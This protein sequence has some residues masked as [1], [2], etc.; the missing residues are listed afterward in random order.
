MKGE[1]STKMATIITNRATVNYNNGS[2]T[3]TVVSNTVSTQLNNGLEINKTA[4]TETYRPDRDITYVITVTNNGS[5]ATERLTVTDD[6]GAYLSGGNRIVPLT[7]IGPSQLFI[8]GISIGEITPITVTDGILFVI[9]NIPANSNAQIIYVARANEFAGGNVDSCIINTVTADNDC[10]CPCDEPVSDSYSVCVDV[11]ADLRVVKC[12]CPDPVVCGERLNYVIELYNYGNIPATDVV[13]TD[14]F[15][16]P[17]T[18]IA[19]SVNG[20]VIPEGDYSYVNG[21]LILPASD[22]EFEITVPA[23]SFIRD[24][25]TGEV[26]VT[27]GNVTVNISGIVS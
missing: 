18:D 8:N 23:A 25:Q 26:S 16:P 17:L 19:V 5:T 13:I 15:T 2:V 6:L 1:S 21:T 20:S 10:F 7:Y 4:L 14:T 12:A 3:S 9:D 24:G 27:P 22:S 11:F